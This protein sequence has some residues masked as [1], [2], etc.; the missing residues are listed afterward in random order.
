[1]RATET[2][3]R[4]TEF[5]HRGAGTDAE[6]RAAGWLARELRASRQPVRVDTF[7][8]RP[9]SAL[10]HAWHVLLALA[11]SLVAVSSPRVGGVLVLLALLSVLADWVSGRSLG[12]RLTP[13]HA[14]QNVVSPAAGDRM[15]LI[16]TANYDAGRTGLAY[17]RPLRRAA[18]AL[19]RAGG[20][21]VPGWLAWLVIELLVLLVVAVLRDGGATGTGV[22]I[23]Q[24]IPTAA[25]VVELAALL[26]L[27]GAG[28]GPSAGDNASGTGVALALAR[29]LHASPPRR[30]D[31]ELVLQGAGESGM[32]G[33]RRHLRA[34]RK[35][36]TA[37]NTIVLGIGPCGAGD[38]TWW[39]SDGPLLP[40]AFGRR[41]QELAAWVAAPGAETPVPTGHRGRG[42]SPALPARMAGL[43]AI[44]IGCLDERGMVPRSHQTD[45][46]VET[47]DDAAIDGL[48]QFAL[49]LVDAVDADL[50]HSQ[51]PTGPTRAA[52]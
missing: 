46:R 23:I 42:T 44:T 47:L 19:R 33:L 15:R 35:E 11:G 16:I 29:A 31:V 43:P 26:E 50:A 3:A 14:T 22:G 24:L 10:A 48:L 20:R 28:Y 45:D 41:L 13:E 32:I 27:A 17:R 18:S 4:L 51:A 52:A 12:R 8:C 7:W 6:R 5:R 36:R 49:T 25:L 9:N 2:A 37:A 39:A 34:R 1:M 38:P 21:L 40:L 30:L